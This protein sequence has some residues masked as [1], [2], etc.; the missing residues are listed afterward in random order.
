MGDRPHEARDYER[1]EGLSG[2]TEEEQ[3]ALERQI[4]E[5]IDAERA[6]RS[7]YDDHSGKAQS[8]C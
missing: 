1:F 8:P 6:L 4:Q 2:P 3:E 7:R 5:D